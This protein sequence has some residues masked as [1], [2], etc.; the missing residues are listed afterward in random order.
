VKTL[1]SAIIA[2]AAICCGQI[3]AGEPLLAPGPSSPINVGR[4]SGR[5]LL[6]DVNGDGHQDL[7]AQ[8]LLTST[9]DILAGDGDGRFSPIN[10]SPMRLSYPPGTIALA[11][12]DHDGILDL[13]IASRN[14]EAEHVHVLKGQGGGRFSPLPGS[15]FTVSLP[16]KTYKPALQFL[17]VNEDGNPDIIA[18]NGRRNTIEILSGDGHGRFSRPS[19][20]TLDS[21]FDFYSFAFADLDS[22][23]HLDV[24]AAMS[25]P[26]VQPGSMAILRGNGKG[27]FKVDPESRLSVPAG[28]RMGTA[29]DL[30]GDRHA[31]VVL[32]HEDKLSVLLN[33]GDGRVRMSKAA[34]PGLPGRAYSVLAGDLDRDGKIDLVVPSVDHRPPYASHILVLLGDRHEFTP[35]AGSPFAAEPGAYYATLG[36]VNEDGKLDVA[37]SS[38]EG[39]G[40][41]LL[42]G[43]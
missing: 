32:I 1:A 9:I 8:H 38:F 27:G 43:R 3:D 21:G 37:A 31:D 2:G 11:D 35:A 4:G 22:D 20:I 19:I 7:L 24:A 5:V 18:A 40:I 16:I 23:G 13:G 34:M 15:P 28:A 14:E 12:V 26:S 39:N 30:N 42:L 6:A 41:T 25:D 10:G 36:D 29:A 33:R 17:D